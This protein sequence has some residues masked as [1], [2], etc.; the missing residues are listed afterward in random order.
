VYKII[1]EK[2]SPKKAVSDLTKME[3]HEELKGVV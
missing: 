2:K 3:I 1:Y